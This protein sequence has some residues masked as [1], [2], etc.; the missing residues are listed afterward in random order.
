MDTMWEFKTASF[1]IRWE[2]EPCQD[3]DLS[4]DETGETAE[5]IENGLWTAFDSKISVSLKY[6]NI[7]LGSAY[8]GQ[9]IYENPGDF[10]DHVGSKGK[11]GSY[12]T[13]MVSEAIH[14]ARAALP[15]PN[16]LA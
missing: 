14:E 12:F 10:R 4:W 13:D 1:I 5:N 8:L 7:E 6:Q 11:W 2:I 16:P 9:S 3:L 15:L